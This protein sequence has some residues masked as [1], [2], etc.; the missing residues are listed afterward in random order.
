MGRVRILAPQVQ[1]RGGHLDVA[2]D[3]RQLAGQ[4]CIR[5]MPRQPVHQLRGATQRQVTHRVHPFIQVFKRG[6]V[7]HQC[8]GRLGTHARHARNV[9]HCVTGKGQVIGIAIGHDA[10]ALLD[11]AVLETLVTG[12]IPIHIARTD[13]LRQVLV[14]RHNGRTQPLG[15]HALRQ[16]ADDVIGLELLAV[17][18]GHAQVRAEFAAA[19]EL[20]HQVRRRRLAIGLVGR[21]DLVAE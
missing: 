10:K 8:R 2:A 12:V 13:Q 20:Q 7:A 9:V 14:A 11:L 19:L 18:P 15:A 6:E 16:R 5:A 3:A 21:V 17:E 4:E 1:P